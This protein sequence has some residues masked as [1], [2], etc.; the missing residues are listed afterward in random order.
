MHSYDP[1]MP[2]EFYKS[3]FIGAWVHTGTHSLF[4]DKLSYA[5]CYVKNVTILLTIHNDIIK[6]TI[7][8]IMMTTSK[9]TCQ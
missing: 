5:R 4:L 9:I 3:A 2:Q 8:V 6:W 1:D 7:L